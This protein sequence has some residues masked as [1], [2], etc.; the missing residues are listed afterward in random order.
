[1]KEERI[2]E[3]VPGGRVFYPQFSETEEGAGVSDSPKILKEKRRKGRP[4]RGGLSSMN[5]FYRSLRDAAV[6]YAEELYRMPRSGVLRYTADYTCLC[7]GD[8]VTVAYTFAVRHRGRTI[9][10]KQLIHRWRG[11]VLL[12][13]GKRKRKSTEKSPGQP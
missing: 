3:A 1:M 9:A 5:R 11:G 13:P 10:E 2:C 4:D 7:E 8:T 12:P 6:Q